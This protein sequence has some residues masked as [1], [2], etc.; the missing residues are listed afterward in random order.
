MPKIT[1]I[2]IAPVGL[3]RKEAIALRYGSFDTLDNVFVAIRADNGMV[4]YGESAPI[5]PTFGETQG[6]IVCRNGLLW[7]T[8]LHQRI[9]IGAIRL[10]V[11]GCD[12]AVLNLNA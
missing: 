2:E 6:T 1:D 12:A 11:A 10:R 3:P 9:A 7:P 4:G 5:P 8:Q